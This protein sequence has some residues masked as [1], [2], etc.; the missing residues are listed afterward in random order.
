MRLLLC[1]T[2]T[3]GCCLGSGC[4]SEQYY[5][6]GQSLQRSACNRL[7]DRQERQR[8]LSKADVPYETYRHDSD[9]FRSSK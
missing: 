3:A 4:S 1:I 2:M 5:A 8:C 9:E 7:I 6:T